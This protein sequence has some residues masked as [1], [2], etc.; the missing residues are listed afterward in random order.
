MS[1][2]DGE[3]TDDPT[4]TKRIHLVRAYFEACTNGRAEDI[5]SCFTHDAV[6]YDT[7][8]SPIR[9][10]TAIGAFW[11]GVR[12]RWAGAIWVADA[13]LEDGDVAAVEWSMHGLTERGRFVFR[14]SEHYRFEED[15]IAEIR[16]YWTFDA[17]EPG[18]ELL[19]YQYDR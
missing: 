18:S 12:D 10:R 14:G 13:G 1:T 11:T 9:G 5:A 19:G 8:H 16:Q 3:T 2:P 15:L 17:E 6:I 7:N 4:P